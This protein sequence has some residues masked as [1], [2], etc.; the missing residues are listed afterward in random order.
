MNQRER[1]SFCR[2]VEKMNYAN[3]YLTEAS[4]TA[5]ESDSAFL[6][7]ET[8]SPSIEEE[9]ADDELPAIEED[10]IPRSNEKQSQKVLKRLNKESIT[11][12]A[13]N[14]FGNF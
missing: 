4:S 13:I 11:E 12:E 1:K 7:T 6:H 14:Q 10:D 8:F 9:V 5:D 2:G 3:A